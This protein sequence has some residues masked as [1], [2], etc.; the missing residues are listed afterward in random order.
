M[1]SE[2]KELAARAES[3]SDAEFQRFIALRQKIA[4][5]KSSATA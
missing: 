1:I 2:L 4:R 3:L 5:T